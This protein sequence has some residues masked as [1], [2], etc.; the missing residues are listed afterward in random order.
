MKNGCVM[1]ASCYWGGGGKS[2]II[3]AHSLMLYQYVHIMGQAA[4]YKNGYTYV[5]VIMHK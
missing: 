1:T 4:K 2:G 3:N 5:S